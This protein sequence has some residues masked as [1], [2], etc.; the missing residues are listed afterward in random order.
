MKLK[1]DSITN[2]YDNKGCNGMTRCHR[3]VDAKKWKTQS[4]VEDGLH[5]KKKLGQNKKGGKS[6]EISHMIKEGRLPK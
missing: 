6:K 4:K 2:I 5:L 1:I 3:L